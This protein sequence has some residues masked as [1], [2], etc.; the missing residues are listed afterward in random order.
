MG[1]GL[2]PG[3]EEGLEVLGVA[4]GEDHVAEAVAVGAGEA[5]V[6]REPLNGAVF[7]AFC[8]EV[9]VV[10]GGVAPAPDVGEEGGA[11]A[12]GDLGVGEAEG[13]E[14]GLLEGGGLLERALRGEGVPGLIELGGGQ[15]FGALVA[16]VVVAGGEEAVAEGVGHGL[17]G[18]VMAGVVAEDGGVGWPRTR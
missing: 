10:A 11:V 2:A 7:E 6:F 3:V 14:G 4:A 16:P 8:P 9:G 15:E 13:G 12:R 17:P 18:G 5:A 1:L